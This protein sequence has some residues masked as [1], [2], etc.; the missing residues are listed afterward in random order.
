MTFVAIG[1]LRVRSMSACKVNYCK[2]VQHKFSNISW[3]ERKGRTI[4]E[5]CSMI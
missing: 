3:S 2:F 5:Y 4:P 1:A